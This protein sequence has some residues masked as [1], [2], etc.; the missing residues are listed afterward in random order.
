MSSC[1]LFCHS[2]FLNNLNMKSVSRIAH[3]NN[4]STSQWRF[5]EFGTLSNF[6]IR[7]DLDIRICRWT[8]S[9]VTF[10]IAKRFVVPIPICHS[11]PYAWFWATFLT[12]AFSANIFVK[13]KIGIKWQDYANINNA[14]IVWLLQGEGAKFHYLPSCFEIC[15]GDN[16]NLQKVIVKKLKTKCG[17]E[18]QPKLAYL[19]LYQLKHAK[20]NA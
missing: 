20:W 17:F 11:K 4:L 16:A 9:Y 2:N 18:W 19:W 12:L 3:H 15:V 8:H 10:Q 6:S 7:F 14:L 5:Y 13:M 1:M